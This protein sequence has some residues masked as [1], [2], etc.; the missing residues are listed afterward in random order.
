MSMNSR[1]IGAYVGIFATL[2][3]AFGLLGYLSVQ[4]AESVYIASADGDMV[5]TLGPIF[6]G[7][8]VFQNSAILQFLALVLVFV[9]G[10]IVGSRE[11]SGRDGALAGGIGGLVGYV[12]LTVS[13]MG[14]LLIAPSE[15]QV[16]A[17]SSILPVVGVAFLLSG[18]AGAIGG[19]IGATTS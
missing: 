10:F 8:V 3:V 5:E 6:A 19:Y 17:V 1:L 12:S 13:A 11:Y 16:F 14:L 9:F 2:G 7:F 15:S 4:W 18:V